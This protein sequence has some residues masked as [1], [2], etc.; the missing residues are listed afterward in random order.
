MVILNFV[1]AWMASAFD[2]TNDHGFEMIGL[3]IDYLTLKVLSLNSDT[4]MQLDQAQI[5]VRTY[6]DAFW[7]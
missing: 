4:Y 7:G 3:G 1:L 6:L 5:I 2:L